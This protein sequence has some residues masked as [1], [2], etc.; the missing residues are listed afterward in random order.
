MPHPLAHEIRSWLTLRA[1][2]GRD[3]H[4]VSFPTLSSYRDW[5]GQ[6]P[7]P[8]ARALAADLGLLGYV[9][10]RL[11]FGQAWPTHGLAEAELDEAKAAWQRVREHPLMWLPAEP[12]RGG[13]GASPGGG[14]GQPRL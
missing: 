13:G 9:L 5:V 3:F 2:M 10:E 7:D 8:A 14:G 6:R 12:V 4:L 1:D 11:A